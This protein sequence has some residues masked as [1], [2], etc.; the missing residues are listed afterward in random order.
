MIENNGIIVGTLRQVLNALDARYMVRVFEQTNDGA[1]MRMSG[2]VMHILE[3]KDIAHLW[4]KYADRSVIAFWF[5]AND[6]VA[7]MLDNGG[8]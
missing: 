6:Y 2:T 3:C 1:E 4:N 8:A 5:Y 7:I